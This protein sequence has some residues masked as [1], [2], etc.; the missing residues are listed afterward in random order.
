MVILRAT[1]ITGTAA[2]ALYAVPLVAA[3]APAYAITDAQVLAGPGD[4]YPVV[5]QINRGTA[6]D[7]N[8]CLPDYSWCD[9]SFG[10]NRGWVYGEQV[11]SAHLDDPNQ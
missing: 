5:G 7:L 10:P 3:A 2:T 6:V 8:R 4:Y 11:T 9:V 1:V